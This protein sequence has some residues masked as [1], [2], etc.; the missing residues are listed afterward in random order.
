MGVGVEVGAGVGVDVGA[1]VGVDVSAGDG[2]DVGTG[3]GVDVAP[4]PVD[5]VPQPVNMLAAPSSIA[6]NTHVSFFANNFF[7]SF[8]PSV[9]GIS[10]LLNKSIPPV[11][12]RFV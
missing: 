9:N 8:R 3:V 7:I 10:L 4:D 6:R 11:F 5:D 1:G 2:I 12:C